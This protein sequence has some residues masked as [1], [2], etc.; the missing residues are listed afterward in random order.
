[1]Q[2]EQHSVDGS[3]QEG[4]HGLFQ[5][6]SKRIRAVDR[7]AP[8]MKPLPPPPPSSDPFQWTSSSTLNSDLLSSDS[9]F[10]CD[11]VY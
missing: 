8:P 10:P 7:K 9:N 6:L 5:T 4:L 1:M 2:V 3:L 11:D